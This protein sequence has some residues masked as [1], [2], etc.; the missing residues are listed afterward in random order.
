MDDG[1]FLSVKEAAYQAGVSPRTVKR[2][3]DEGKLPAVD[4]GPT[5]RLRIPREEFERVM[6]PRPHGQG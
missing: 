3:V 1:A 2:W 5:D 6:R 4:V